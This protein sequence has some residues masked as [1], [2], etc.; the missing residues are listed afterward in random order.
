MM[1]P[2]LGN[3]I[4]ASVAQKVVEKPLSAVKSALSRYREAVALQ[5][6]GI[7]ER[8]YLFV[9]GIGRLAFCILLWRTMVALPMQWLA[10][11]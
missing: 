2:S 10:Y 6:E 3:K 1:G 8:N 5:V 9:V 7:W 11:Q 4:D